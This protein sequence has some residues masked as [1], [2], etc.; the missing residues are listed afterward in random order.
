M[1]QGVVLKAKPEGH[2]LALEPKMDK[3]KMAVNTVLDTIE[4]FNEQVVSPDVL[5]RGNPKYYLCD[6][7]YCAFYSTCPYVK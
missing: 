1:I 2:V 5:F 6:P 7:K 3:A 4:V